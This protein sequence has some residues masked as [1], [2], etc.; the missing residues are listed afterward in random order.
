MR[1]HKPFRADA[2]RL[3]RHTYPDGT[4][5]DVLQ[6]S[7]VSEWTEYGE[8]F[9]TCGVDVEWR[10]VPLWFVPYEPAK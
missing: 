7:F 2:L 4:T 1:A 10:D 3:A 5:K 8:T 9:N 6:Q